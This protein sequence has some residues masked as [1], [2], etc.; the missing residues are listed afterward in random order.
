MTTP[1]F[2]GDFHHARLEDLLGSSFPGV[3]VA[4]RASV[5][6]PPAACSSLPEDVLALHRRRR[7]A[8]RHQ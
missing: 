6:I 1:S 2:L 8:D 5:A 4:N 3:K 7:A